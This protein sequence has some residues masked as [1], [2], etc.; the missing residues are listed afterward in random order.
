M[1]P[2]V[3]AVAGLAGLDHAVAA[4]RAPLDLQRTVHARRRSGRESERLTRD[5]RRDRSVA[6]LGRLDHAVTGAARDGARGSVERAPSGAG[7]RPALVAE[8]LAGLCADV[9][10]VALLGP[11]DHV[12]SAVRAVRLV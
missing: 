6:L 3:R 10:A 11:V 7:E 5:V 12:V 1:P 2:Q 4:V 8:A 9:A